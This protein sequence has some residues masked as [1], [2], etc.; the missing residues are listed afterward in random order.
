MQKDI[1]EF[2]KKPRYVIECRQGTHFLWDTFETP[3]TRLQVI[4]RFKDFEVS[5]NNWTLW[6]I[7]DMREVGVLK[8][9][10]NKATDIY[11]KTYSVDLTKYECSMCKEKYTRHS[12]DYS[13]DKKTC[14]YCAWY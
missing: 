12:E 13:M 2:R 3:L 4:E 8:V 9:K 11:D 14:Y 7:A 5:S 10:W 1:V 6:F